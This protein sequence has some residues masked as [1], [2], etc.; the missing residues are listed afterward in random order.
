MDGGAGLVSSTYMVRFSFNIEQQKQFYNC[1]AN[2]LGAVWCSYNEQMNH[3]RIY[4][5]LVNKLLTW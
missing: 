1:E 3:L 2:N 4:R 5:R